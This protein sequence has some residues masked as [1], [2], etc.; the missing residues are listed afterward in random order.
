L[1]LKAVLL[2]A[3]RDVELVDINKPEPKEGDVL[4]KV[5]SC[6]ICGTDLHAYTG[7]LEDSWYALPQIPGH[8]FSGEVASVGGSVS[9]VSLGDRVTVRP[10]ISC[11][12]CQFCK[13]GD[14]YR[15]DNFQ[16][17]GETVP[18]AMAEYVVVPSNLVHV[19][20]SEVSFTEGAMVEPLAV[21]FHAARK[22]R[23]K[24]S[25]VIIGAGTIGLLIMQAI[26]ALGA[27]KIIVSDILN[28]RL[29]L[30]SK[31]GADHVFNTTDQDYVSQVRKAAGGFGVDATFEAVGKPQTLDLC[32][33][34]TRKGG[35]I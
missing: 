3:P 1:K 24:D 18:G 17:I 27:K 34:P 12:K 8:E 20:P 11:G 5:N 26:R 28:S 9:N 33:K 4:I 2:K 16:I 13:D 32:L 31:L 7:K 19:I 25:V 23:R 14:E 10:L 30:A 15:C 29:D 35:E 22:V 21:A 6:G